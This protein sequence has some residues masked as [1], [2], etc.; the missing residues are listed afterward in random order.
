MHTV[1]LSLGSDAVEKAKRLCLF[2]GQGC[3]VSNLVR[4]SIDLLEDE[5]ANLS[6]DDER[7]IEQGI[8]AGH[9]ASHPK[10][11]PIK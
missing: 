7:L 10:A 5:I 9:L 11:N 6:S 1:N 2:Y 4:R 8:M 3:S